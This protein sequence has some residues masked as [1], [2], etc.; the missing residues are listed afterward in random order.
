MTITPKALW[1]ETVVSTSAAAIYTSP[2]NTTTVISRA[3]ITNVGAAG[4]QLTLWVVRSGGARADGNIIVGASAGGQ[5]I[6]AG[7]SEPYVPAALAGL[8]LAPG[9]ALHAK[10]DTASVLNAIGSGWT[11]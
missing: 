3:A 10:S 7:A 11:Q 4:A 9:D 5:V 8:T 2:A 6:S 1:G